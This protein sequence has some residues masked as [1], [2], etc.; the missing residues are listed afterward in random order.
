M[1]PTL[2]LGFDI[3][4]KTLGIIGA[5]RIGTEF[6]LGTKGFNMKVIYFDRKKNPT[7]EKK[8]NAKKV[9][10][11]KLLQSSDFISIHTP[12]TKE[13]HHLIG[14]KEI[15]LMKKNVIIIN[16]S[17]GPVINEEELTEAL[18]TRAIAGAGLDVYEKEPS[19][20]KRLQR[21]NNVVLTPHIGSASYETREKMAVMAAQSIIDVGKGKKP[22][23][24]V[25]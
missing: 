4:G 10:F 18:E 5:G 25:N 21:C 13:T 3:H 11:K 8:V 6:A 12:L 19:I 20:T 15:G 1:E 14:K 23:N 7:I 24:I 16:T 2:L 17:R 9:G 22:K